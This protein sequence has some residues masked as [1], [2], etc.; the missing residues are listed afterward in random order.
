MI[1]TNKKYESEVLKLFS[2]KKIKKIIKNASSLTI[3]IPLSAVET[4]GLFYS[5]TRALAWENINIIDIVSTFTEMTFLIDEDETGRA[6]DALK[7]L[8]EADS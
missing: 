4:A 8:I 2:K 1:I 3:S 7:K 6:F 5:A